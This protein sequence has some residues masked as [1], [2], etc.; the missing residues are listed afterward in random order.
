MSVE[1]SLLQ[2]LALRQ[3]ARHQQV[4]ASLHLGCD[5]LS[6]KP[7]GHNHTL[8]SPLMAQYLG[9]EVA[10]LAGHGSVH[11]VIR[12]HNSPGLILLN[13]NLKRLQIN[14][15]ECARS[16]DNVVA[17]AVG[18]LIV[19]GE[20]LERCAHAVALHAVDHCCAN[21]AR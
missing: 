18:L 7:V 9:H 21:L 13:D 12:C 15:A 2:F 16:A 19:E 8:E 3:L 17:C 5:M 6:A 10:T 14:L 11:F 1:H 4:V 20:V